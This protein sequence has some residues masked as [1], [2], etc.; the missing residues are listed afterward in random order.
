M[1]D[2]A[3]RRIQHTKSRRAGNLSAGL[4]ALILLIQ[5][6]INALIKMAQRPAQVIHPDIDKNIKL[7][8]SLK[9]R[10]ALDPG[11]CENR[12]PG[13]VFITGHVV[14]GMIACD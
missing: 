14:F 4:S 1:P 7:G 5:G 8:S 12:F 13:I 2:K 6:Q 9:N 10:H 3:H 11:F